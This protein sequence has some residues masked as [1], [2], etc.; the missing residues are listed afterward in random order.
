MNSILV[1]CLSLI[2][3]DGDT[4]KCDGINYRLIGDGVP[5]RNGFDAPEIHRP[6][7]RAERNMGMKAKARLRQIANQKGIMIK[8]TGKRD[9]W[10]RSL[11]SLVTPDGR[12][13]GGILI[14]EGLA[15]V[16][17]EPEYHS[18]CK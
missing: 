4:V 18:W 1:V 15:V 16:W 6:Q 13:A 7:C 8:D 9:R 17:P 12:T 11:G 10:G 3:I 5:G 2:V 14:D